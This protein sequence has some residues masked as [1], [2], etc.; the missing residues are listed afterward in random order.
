MRP[1]V[2]WRKGSLG[3]QTG[4]GNTFVA[5]PLSVAAISQQHRSLCSFT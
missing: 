2:L 3:T 4:A 1:A 5:R